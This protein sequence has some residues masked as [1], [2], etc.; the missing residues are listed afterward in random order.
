MSPVRARLVHR[1]TGARHLAAACALLLASLVSVPRA[2]AQE[3]RTNADARG[4]VA[5]CAT[6]FPWTA[7]ECAE[8]LGDGAGPGLVL[9]F[10]TAPD[11]LAA[12]QRTWERVALDGATDPGDD[13][14][15]VARVERASA[16]ELLGGTWLEWWSVFNHASR[17][18]SLALALREAQRRGVP[19]L[20]CD[21][22]ASHVARAALVPR[23]VIGKPRR[24]PR[25]PDPDVQVAGLG[26][27]PVVWETANDPDASLAA[28]LRALLR[29]PLDG[30]LYATGASALVIEPGG[31]LARV[32]AR[33]DGAVLDID[34]SRAR[35]MR[36]ALR[37]GR[38]TL[39]KDGARWELATHAPAGAW[40][41][42]PGSPA[43][44]ERRDVTA[45]ALAPSA[46]T[47]ALHAG[48]W[49]DTCT[50]TLASAGVEVRF[51]LTPD[52]LRAG[53]ESGDAVLAHVTFDVAWEFP[54]PGAEPSAR[55][56]A[57]APR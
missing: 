43:G 56:P 44:A 18:T 10:G 50:R 29:R 11:P 6:A 28:V 39:G 26:L 17:T 3:R 14:E 20:A 23:S 45:D 13:A 48:A 1:R 49:P 57:P 37:E 31:A 52:S 4:R 8:F 36:E 38:V 55:P 53:G 12:S 16:L 47:A 40:S 25:T 51:A 54:D 7:A 22:A 35:R 42:F 27:A 15:L 5:L 30:A 19:L 32:I 21:G 2:D 33:A 34:L 41:A 46:W 24:N 9:A